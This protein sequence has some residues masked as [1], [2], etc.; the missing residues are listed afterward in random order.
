MWVQYYWREMIN[1]N[2]KDI[3]INDPLHN[4]TINVANGM[5]ELAPLDII[6]DTGGTICL[7]LFMIWFLVVFIK[8]FKK[9]YYEESKVATPLKLRDDI[10]IEECRERLE[11]LRSLK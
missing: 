8:N 1:S 10:T 2:W 7:L 9:G 3:G 5:I 4:H 11:W 6:I